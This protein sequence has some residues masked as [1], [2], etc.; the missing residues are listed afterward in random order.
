[1]GTLEIAGGEAHVAQDAVG[2]VA[3]ALGLG[4]GGVVAEIIPEL[5]EAALRADA[6]G[7]CC[8]PS[9]TIQILAGPAS[10]GDG[11]RAC[12]ARDTRFNALD[13]GVAT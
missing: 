7:V 11:N 13:F 5:T 1:M 2:A 6:V 10:W 4:G 12:S 8:N 3:S 9:Q